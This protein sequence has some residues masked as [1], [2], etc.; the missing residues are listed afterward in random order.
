MWWWAV[1]PLCSLWAAS[2]VIGIIH[3]KR[4][5]RPPDV[6]IGDPTD[7]YLRRWWV[8]PRNPVF[9]IYLHQFLKSDTDEALHDHPWWNISFLLKGEYLEV[10][11]RFTIHPYRASNALKAILRRPGNPV[12]RRATA[13]HRVLLLG[14]PK[15]CPVWS[16]FVTGPVVREWGF[17]CPQGWRHWKQFTVRDEQG[18][19]VDG[20]GCD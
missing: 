10:V 3:L 16:L 4:W 19:Y 12:F 2:S 11:P 6:T 9:N 14:E 18:N 8:I 13:A 7:P 20:K 1:L 5:P 15:P 17:H